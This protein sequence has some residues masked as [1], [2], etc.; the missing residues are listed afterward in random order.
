MEVSMRLKKKNYGRG[1]SEQ[2]QAGGVA[3]AGDGPAKTVNH[4]GHG[5]EAVEPAP[6]RGHERR[7]IGDRRGK[8]PEGDDEGNDVANIAIQR[9]ERGEPE[10]DAESGEKR[11]KKQNGKPE[12]RER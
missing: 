12:R 2:E 10:A 4:A 9:V 7:S 1:G 8:H 11:E 5:I 6:T 3:A